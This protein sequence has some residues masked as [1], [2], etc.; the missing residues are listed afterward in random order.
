MIDSKLPVSVKGIVLRKKNT[1]SE[2]LLSRNERQEWE[3]PGGRIEVNETPETCLMREFKEETELQVAIGPCVGSGILTIA[4]PHV[5]CA[6]DVWIWGYGCHLQGIA[7]L[8]DQ[9]IAISSEHKGWSWIP[10]AELDGMADVPDIYKVC[11]LTWADHLL[12]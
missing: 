11:I 5:P 7:P 6:T 12:Y 2:V 9:G 1:K 10:V 8:A 3:L 4:P